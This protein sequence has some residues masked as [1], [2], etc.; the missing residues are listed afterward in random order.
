MR[1]TEIM[2]MTAFWLSLL[3]PFKTIKISSAGIGGR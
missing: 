3:I 1:S 2:D